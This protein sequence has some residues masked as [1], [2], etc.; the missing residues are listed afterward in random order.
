MQEYCS[1]GK[2]CKANPMEYVKEG[3]C[4][5]KY[6]FNDLADKDLPAV[7]IENM[8]VISGF[9]ERSNNICGILSV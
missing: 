3:L 2:R 4:I 8:N 6:V 1:E 5:C 9:R 7:I